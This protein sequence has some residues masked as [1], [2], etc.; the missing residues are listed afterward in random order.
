MRLLFIWM[1]LLWG[2]SSNLSNN[3]VSLGTVDFPGGRNGQISWEDILRFKRFSWY[4]G[5]T[6]GYD[7]LIY[8]VDKTS[9]FVNWFSKAERDLLNRCKDLIVT[10]N[11]SAFHS[12]V[13]HSDFKEVMLVGGYNEVVLRR[14]ANSLKAH[15]AFEAWN[16]QQ[17]KVRGFCHPTEKPVQ[18]IMNFPSFPEAIV[19]F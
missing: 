5:V 19:K 11:Y 16:L 2:C 6:L 7:A 13:K 17:Y 18:L 1:I 12:L 10:V 15:P 14:F 3:K 4:R 9:K 8:R